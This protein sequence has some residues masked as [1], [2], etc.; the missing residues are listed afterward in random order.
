MIKHVS[1]R[2]VAV[3][4]HLNGTRE[5][6]ELTL[7][8]VLA[9][10]LSDDYGGG[11]KLIVDW[12][13]GKRTIVGHYRDP[14]AA[15]GDFG[16]LRILLGLPAWPQEWERAPTS[17]AAF[18]PTG[19]RRSL[20]FDIRHA[21]VSGCVLAALSACIAG[22]SVSWR[23]APAEAAA[24]PAPRSTSRPLTTPGGSARVSGED[25]NRS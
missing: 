14:S 8:T 9:V 22:G 18:G 11:L 23:G 1:P 7:D 16:K 13:S 3:I 6:H 4:S 10:H 21:I 19:A 15:G 20:S 24:D 5:V 12:F 25:G 17:G 2:C